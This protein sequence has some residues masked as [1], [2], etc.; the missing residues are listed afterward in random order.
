MNVRRLGIL[1]SCLVSLV[2]LVGLS[3]MVGTPS[4]QAIPFSLNQDGCTGGCG[5]GSTVFG[6]VDVVQGV[7][8]NHVNVTVTLNLPSMFVK[9][10]A[11]EALEFNIT[12]DPAITITGLTSGFSVGP[13]PASASVFG[14]FDY[15]I[16][17]SG[18]GNGGSGPHP[19]PPCVPAAT[20]PPASFSPP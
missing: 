2:A 13:A 7:D 6:T 17:C 1:K 18:C 9:T 5:S 11:G 3:F 19:P 15:S 20:R 8:A 12:G 4:A 16:H 10:G 14:A